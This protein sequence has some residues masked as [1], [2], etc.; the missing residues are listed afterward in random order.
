M[1]ASN[2]QLERIENSIQSLADNSENSR[3]RQQATGQEDT[4]NDDQPY[5]YKS[6]AKSP[7]R[8][9]NRQKSQTT[10]YPSDKG[11]QANKRKK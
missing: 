3:D 9:T 4:L 7:L 2:R 6:S 11:T 1:K 5:D 8:A 10:V